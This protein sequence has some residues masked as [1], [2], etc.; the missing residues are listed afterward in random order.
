MKLDQVPSLPEQVNTVI[1]E[2]REAAQRCMPLDRMRIERRLL[3]FNLHKDRLKELGILQEKVARSLQLV[4]RRRKNRPRTS[5]PEDLPISLRR[6]EIQRAIVDNQVVVVAGDTGS[7]KS[8]QLPKICLDAGR[9]LRGKIACTQPR[10]VAALSVSRRIAEELDVTW[11]REVGSK[12]RFKDH[13]APETYIKMVTDGILLAEIQ[14]DADLWEYDT[15]IVDEAHERS[16]NIDFLIGYLRLLCQRRTDLK[17]I[18]TSATIDTEAFSLAFDNAPI[19]EVHGRMFPVEVRYWPL[20]ELLEAR[21]DYTYVDAVLKAVEQTLAETREG[22]LLV[23][24]PSEN[25]IL[26][27]G[28]R[29]RERTEGVEILPLFGR[30]SAAE[31]HRLFRRG[32]QRR[33]VLS[34]NV[35]ETSLTVPGIRYVVDTGLARMSRYNPRSHTHRLPI[36]PVSQSSADQ[37]KGRCG[38]LE[39]GIC[40]R[41]YSEEDFLSRPQFTVPELQRANLADVILQMLAHRIGDIR[42]F[43]FLDAPT[44]QAIH[45][46]IR[47]L[48]ELGALNQSQRITR[49]GRRMARMPIAPTVARMVLQANREGVLEDV[50][51]VAAAISIQ[52]PRERP[53]ERKSQADEAHHQFVHPD[54]DFLTL[55]NIW[56]AFR[57]LGAR[58]SSGQ[59]RRFCKENFL[60]FMRM[61]EWQDI[62]QQLRETLRELGGFKWEHNKGSYEGIHRSVLSGLLSNV[63]M[64]LERNLY[65]AARGR[66]VMIFPGSGLFARG[67]AKK[68][69][70]PGWLVAAEIVETSRL[71]A[72]TAARIQ[73]EWLEALGSHLCRY[74]HKEPSY[75]AHA[76]RVLVRETVTLHGLEILQRRVPYKHIDPEA[77]TEIFIR[78]ALVPGAVHTPHRFLERNLA[79][80]HKVETWQTR[81]REHHGLDVEESAFRFYAARL[82]DVSSVHDLNRIVRAGSRDDPDFLVMNERDLIGS[83]DTA[84]NKNSFPDYLEMEGSRLPLTYAYCP[85]EE[86]D[87]LTLALPCKLIE[88]LDPQVLEWLVPGFIEEKIVHYLRKLPKSLRRQLIPIPEKAR[89]TAAAIRPDGRPF[90][91]RLAAFVESEYGVRISPRDWDDQPLPNHLRMRVDIK[92]RDDQTL[93]AGRDLAS[94]AEQLEQHD[95]P[96]ELEIWKRATADWEQSELTTWSFGDLPERIEIADV[97]GLPLLAFPGLD[98]ADRGVDLRLFRN[99]RE[100]QTASRRGIFRLVQIQLE[101]ELAWL[102]RN[103]HELDLFQPQSEFIGN[104]QAVR[105]AALM[106]LQQH[107]IEVPESPVLAVSAFESL[108]DRALQESTGLGTRFVDQFKVIIQLRE[109]IHRHRHP[110]PSIEDDLHRLCGAS[111]LI[112]TPFARLS[113]LQRYL[114]GIL[115]RAERFG[116]D[117]AKD[118][119]KATQIEPFERELR[120]YSDKSCSAARAE[121]LR[122]LRW[123]LEE[124]RVSLFA[125]ELGTDRPISAQRL[126]HKLEVLRAEP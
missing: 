6:T 96:V 18:I 37:R 8:T 9:G 62:Y 76:A 110:Y 117:P 28:E 16:L 53:I 4:E 2:L 42:T 48:Q 57:A 31:Q 123:M 89:H 108:V 77:A 100:A 87:G 83:R 22:D 19:V 64:K 122:E 49:L 24:L 86:E 15:I 74:S 51:V 93:V 54:S 21:D 102:E 98:V 68:V 36:E 52:D 94:M 125:Q 101:E 40:I 45:G 91:E 13:T 118:R 27:I 47:Q 112:H 26:E 58:P 11:G 55:A 80:Q 23:F 1:G 85:G 25:D 70:T 34:T 111:F 60:S 17:V 106:H 75:N 88:A 109:E 103:L 39:G 12:I 29:L 30:L 56:R 20:E 33:I 72:R 121:I 5:Y 79:L 59:L 84:V 115:I 82:L 3:R 61:R 69:K 32:D 120:E 43:P 7:G 41:L 71:F 126:A 35:A 116:L 14:G 95:T 50:L 67:D 92:G 46:G 81:I 44:D 114:R 38:R 73:P 66:E 99:R 65:R 104:N 78:E 105:A 113:H 97:A 107:L 90:L 63:A 119:Q 124:F 10:R